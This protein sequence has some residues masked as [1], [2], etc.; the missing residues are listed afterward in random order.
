MGMLQ[1]LLIT[2]P[3]PLLTLPELLKIIYVHNL[4]NFHKARLQLSY[5]ISYVSMSMPASIN[6]G[7]TKM[8]I[9][10]H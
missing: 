5:L 10:T 9:I 6:Y 3:F 2:G 1:G 4:S 7:V 8:S